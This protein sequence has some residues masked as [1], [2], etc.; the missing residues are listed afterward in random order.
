MFSES[1]LQGKGMK[2]LLILIFAVSSPFTSFGQVSIDT[3]R[4]GGTANGRAEVIRK[5]SNKQ[6][7]K[8]QRYNAFFIG[9]EYSDANSLIQ[10]VQYMGIQVRKPF[11][12]APSK[13]TPPNTTLGKHLK[14]TEL[15]KAFKEIK[16]NY[17]ILQENRNEV[18][19]NPDDTIVNGSVLADI[20]KQHGAKPIFFMTWADKKKPEQHKE[21]L[22]TYETLALKNK[23]RMSPVGIA[24][25]RARKLAPHIKLYREDTEV[26][27]PTPHG[28]YL[29]AACLFVTIFRQ[30]PIGQK[31]TGFKVVSEKDAL[32]LQRI[33][34]KTVMDYEK[35][36]VNKAKKMQAEAEK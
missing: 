6:P 36:I 32:L 16:W 33:A 4:G 28:T 3:G 26:S 31:Q 19:N 21:I 20:V 11:E 10:V 30:S 23:C 35:Y 18:I 29:T 5:E 13:I 34:Y 2:Y 8:A 27:Y 17:V 24:W 7:Q 25:E 1:H 15:P 9:D 22:K 14:N 12:I